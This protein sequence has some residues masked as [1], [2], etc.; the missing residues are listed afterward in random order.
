VASEKQTMISTTL[1]WHPLLQFLFASRSF[2]VAGNALY[3]QEMYSIHIICD[4]KELHLSKEFPSRD[5]HIT[6]TW[7]WNSWAFF[8]RLFSL[9][10]CLQI[11]PFIFYVFYRILNQ[12]FIK[13]ISQITISVL[14]EVMV[15][16]DG[17]ELKNSISIF[18]SSN[19]NGFEARQ[20]NF[21]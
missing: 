13:R 19:A 9:I 5:I 3:H 12:L 11:M 6:R 8:S 21:P 4:F 17:F 20:I 14:G 7:T 1:F 2:L 18:F 10:N 16:N 15:P